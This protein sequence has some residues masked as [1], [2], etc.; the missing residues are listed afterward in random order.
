MRPTAAT[1]TTKIIVR[2]AATIPIPGSWRS[3]IFRLSAFLCRILDILGV[4]IIVLLDWEVAGRTLQR[5]RFHFRASYAAD[6]TPKM[7]D[8]Y[9]YYG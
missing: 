7:K 9:F 1:T 2:T 3:I 8:S 5:A 6:I 4:G